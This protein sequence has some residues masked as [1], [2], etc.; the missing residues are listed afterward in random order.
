[1]S[2][3]LLALAA[4]TLWST[5]ALLS[6]PLARVP[7]LLVMGITLTTGGLLSAPRW[8]AWRVPPRTLAL[9]LYGL[10]AYHLCLFVALRRAPAVEAN[11]INYLWPLLLVLLAPMVLPGTR[12]AAR[13]V[14]GG[15]AGCVGAM[16]VIAGRGATSGGAGHID[17]YLFAL[18]AAFIW[19]TY[20][21]LCKRVA[22]F[23]TAAVGL[24][25][26]LSGALALACHALFEPRYAPDAG[27]WLRLGALGLGPLG[28]AFYLWDAA[29]KRGDPRTIGLLSNL[30]PL[31]ST[32]WLV[33]GGQGHLTWVTG[34]AA[35][36]I[37]GGAALGTLA[38]RPRPTLLA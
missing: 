25:C 10:F 26:L 16:L 5:L 31:L 6:V 12:L 38:Q 1:M 17:G 14:A 37:V 22:A 36:L 19:A 7:P 23:S 11:L 34:V 15:V 33:L 28:A 21:L 32:A 4:I 8:R 13:H 24:F 29:L 2:S 18:A 30:T 3:N 35:L 20:S 9:G 27:E